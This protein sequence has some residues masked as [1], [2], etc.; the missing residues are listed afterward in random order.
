[1]TDGEVN[2]YSSRVNKFINDLNKEKLKRYNMK[3]RK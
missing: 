3:I 1:M 2:A